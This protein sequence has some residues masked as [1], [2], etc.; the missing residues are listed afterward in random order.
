[1]ETKKNNE[2]FVFWNYNQMNLFI[3][4]PYVNSIGNAFKNFT[5]LHFNFTYKYF[6]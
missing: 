2:D 1:M 3:L 6:I 5:P 4:D